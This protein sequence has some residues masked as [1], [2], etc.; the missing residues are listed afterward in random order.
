MIIIITGTPCTGK[1]TV[2]KKLAKALNH[3]YL[4][5]NSLLKDSGICDGYD[6]KNECMVVDPKQLNKLLV[7]EIKKNPKLV[8][9]SHLSHFLPKKYVD[10]CIVCKC[11]LPELKRRLKERGYHEQKIRDNLDAEIFDVCLTE[12]QEEMGHKVMIVDT[13]EG[14]DIDRVVQRIHDETKSRGS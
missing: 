12:A 11:E 13:T 2:S 5:A 8:I 6:E 10:I 9:D 7:K 3:T 14:Y 4:D 1:S